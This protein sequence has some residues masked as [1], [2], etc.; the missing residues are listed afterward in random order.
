[1]EKK[2]EAVNAYIIKNSKGE[3]GGGGGEKK[4]KKKREKQ[5]TGTRAL[6]FYFT[7]IVVQSLLLMSKYKIT[8]IIYI[9]TGMSE[10]VKFDTRDFPDKTYRLHSA[11]CT[12][13][14]ITQLY[15]M[16]IQPVTK[17]AEHI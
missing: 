1:M 15:I 9:H 12:H 10:R 14:C 8:G 11:R 5:R 6:N 3:R 2:T 13:A 17:A 16:S 7:R 4:E